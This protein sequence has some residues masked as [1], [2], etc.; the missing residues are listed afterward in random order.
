MSRNSAGSMGSISN[1]TAASIAAHG[2]HTKTSMIKMLIDL[3]AAG[4]INDDDGS[5]GSERSLR[6][7]LQHAVEE[8]SKAMTPYG[9]VVQKN[10]LSNG[11][12]WEY[13]HPCA[14]LWYM[15][16][17]SSNFCTIMRD[18]VADGR[19]ARL[20]IYAD[21]MIPGNPFRPEKSRKL[22][23]IYWAFVDWPDWLLTRSFAWPC[24]SVLRSAMVADVDAGMSYIARLILHVFFPDTGDSLERGIF[25]RSPNGEQY[26]IKAIFAGWLCDLAGHKDILCW[27]GWQGN[28]CCFGCRNLDRRHRGPMS[29]DGVIGIDCADTTHFNAGQNVT[30]DTIFAI[31]DDLSVQKHTLVKSAFERYA[32]KVGFNHVPNGL[33]LDMSLRRLYK[34]ME[35]TLRDW[36]HTLVGDGVGNTLVAELITLIAQ[37]G[38]TI[39]QVRAFLP[40]C[41]LPKKYGTVRAEWLSPNRLKHN[42]LSSFSSIVLSLVPLLQLFLAHFC[43]D[44]PELVDVTRMFYLFHILLGVLS[45]G[46]SEAHKNAT[47]LRALIIEF[48]TLFSQLCTSL[49]PKLHHMH[50]IIDA[51]EWL[52]KCLSCFVTERKHRIVKDSA[53]HVFRH[54]EHTVLADVINKQCHQFVQGVDLFKRDFLHLPRTIVGS[55]AVL[56]SVDAVLSCGLLHRGDIC[57]LRD[58][59][60][61]RIAMFYAIDDTIIVD[62]SIFEFLDGEPTTLDE[63]RQSRMFIDSNVVVDAVSWFQSNVGVITIVIPPIVLI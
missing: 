55:P 38:F 3:R 16:Q 54:I 49:K 4:A 56:R 17:I 7:K 14:F 12:E 60:V 11:F 28:V 5:A 51:L 27:K 10:R 26:M 21:E 20:V 1:A 13:C 29:A 59:R 35:H 57:W 37:R 15:S 30:S 32:T 53:L 52:G 34:P 61:G 36:Q 63:S 41:H 2:K 42:T 50:H 39:D 44:D 19:P 40:L 6:R 47:K 33:L 46:P 25:L 22:L 9:P 8:H 18:S 58:A 23:C 31:I 48:H 24:F 45:T 62:F 43:K